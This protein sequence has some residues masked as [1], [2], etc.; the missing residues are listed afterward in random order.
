MLDPVIGTI[1]DEIKARYAADTRIA[2]LARAWH[3]AVVA[4]GRTRAAV[5]PGLD[6]FNDE[7]D[8]AVA[9]WAD[10][11]RASTAARR[12]LLAALREEA[13]SNA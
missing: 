12:A 2:N 8:P 13:Q 6:P 10:A 11:E 5:P 9:A 7:A 3:A 4:A 1:A